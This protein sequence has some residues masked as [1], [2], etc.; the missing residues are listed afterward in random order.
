MGREKKKGIILILLFVM[1]NL[2]PVEG[3]PP[4]IFLK[5]L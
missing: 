3:E 2:K 1:G 5:I 4:S